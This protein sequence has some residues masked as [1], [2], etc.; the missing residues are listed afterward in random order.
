MNKY[1][2][3]LTIIKTHIVDY[4]EELEEDIYLYSSYK[5]EFDTLQ[6]LIDQTKTPTLE[7]V[8]KEWEALGYE[9]IY[10]N[11]GLINIKHKKDVAKD[12]LIYT[13][14]K[15]YISIWTISFQEHQLLTK[16]FRALGWEV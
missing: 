8:K 3:A 12:I 4:D 6:E 13:S 14:S 2:E 9:W 16:T 5:E 7:E 11:D 15:N 10:K 1:Q